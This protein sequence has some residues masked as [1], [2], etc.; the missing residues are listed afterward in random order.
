MSMK[1]FSDT[2]GNRTRDLTACSAGGN[3]LTLIYGHSVVSLQLSHEFGTLG[4]I[5]TCLLKM[6]FFWLAVQLNALSTMM[7][8]PNSS[9]GWK[10]T[11][12]IFLNSFMVLLGLYLTYSVAYLLSY[13]HT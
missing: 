13:F 11:I 6:F 9:P 7:N 3:A 12:V 4:N 1:N 5:T 10:R 2:M 8:V